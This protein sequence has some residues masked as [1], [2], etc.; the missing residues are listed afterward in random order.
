MS[1]KQ[2]V[3]NTP[4]V[5]AL[6]RRIY[7]T[8]TN[9]TDSFLN[10][11][12]YWRKRYESG[13]NSGDGSYGHLAIFKSEIINDFVSKMH[14]Q[15]IIEYGCGDGNQLKFALYPKYIGFDVSPEATNICSRMFSSD[16]T[17]VFKLMSDY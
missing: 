4:V 16:S 13:G 15:S 10:S 1:I 5:G 12:N 17:K 14:I 11:E 7:R 9:S 3:K 2:A 6:V 8:L